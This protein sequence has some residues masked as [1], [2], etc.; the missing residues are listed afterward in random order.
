MIKLITSILLV[1]LILLLIYTIWYLSTTQLY[2]TVECISCEITSYSIYPDIIYT[3]TR[4]NRFFNIVI[5][6]KK[7][8]DIERRRYISSW[9]S[10]WDQAE[11]TIENFNGTLQFYKYI[12]NDSEDYDTSIEY[13]DIIEYQKRIL[14][15]FYLSLSFTIS[16]ILIK[17]LNNK[18]ESRNK[19]YINSYKII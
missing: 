14:I 13:L 8:I 1:P 10:E 4:Y 17:C 6:I 7:C 2:D 19:K 9:Y 3:G 11:K 12:R 5:N 15:M 18:F 16:L